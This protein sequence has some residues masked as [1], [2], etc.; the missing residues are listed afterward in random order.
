MSEEKD[1]MTLKCGMPESWDIQ[2]PETWSI[3]KR[4]FDFSNSMSAMPQHDTDERKG[5]AVSSY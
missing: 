3:M 5:I 1:Y 2:N 4:Y